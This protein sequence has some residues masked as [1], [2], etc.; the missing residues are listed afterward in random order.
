MKRRNIILWILLAGLIILGHGSGIA[1]QN[2]KLPA[3]QDLPLSIN[4]S[5]IGISFKQADYLSKQQYRYAEQVIVRGVVE[6]QLSSCDSLVDAQKK[7]LL[8]YRSLNHEFF[9]KEDLYKAQMSTLKMTLDASDREIKKQRVRT[10]LGW[11]GGGL[12]GVGAGI[13]IG[14]LIVN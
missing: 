11:V 9:K 13:L 6:Q 14:I 8:S 2:D 3:V 10:V 12:V 5:I 1:Q 4:D 7:L